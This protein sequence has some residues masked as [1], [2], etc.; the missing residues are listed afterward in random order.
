[1]KSGAKVEN[2]WLSPQCLG[3][4][5]DKAP[6]RRAGFCAYGGGEYLCSVTAEAERQARQLIRKTRRQNPHAQIVVTG[7]A[8]QIDPQSWQA[9]DEVDAVMG[10]H[11]KLGAE[12]WQALAAHNSGDL[13]SYIGDIMQVREVAPH[14]LSGFD[15]K[16]RAFL[17]IQQG[18]DHRCS[19]CIIPYGRGVSRSVSRADTI[20][21]IEMLVA[22]GVQEVV[23]TGV[24]ISSWGYDLGGYDLGADAPPRLG[25]LVKAILQAVPLLPRLRLSSLDPA[26]IDAD[27]RDAFGGEER[28]MPHAHLSIQHGDGLMLKRMKR[29]HSPDDVKDLVEDLRARRRDIVFGGDIIAGF[30]TETDEAHQRS[31]EF[32]ESL[33]ISWLHIFPF[34][35]RNGTP[36]ARMPQVSGG[37]IRARAGEFRQLGAA[38]AQRQLDAMV[39]RTDEVVLETGGIAHTRQFAKVVMAAGEARLTAGARYPVRILRAD[40]QFLHAEALL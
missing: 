4:R 2:F 39:G 8:A 9:M 6:Y 32:I 3:K 13:P 37:V 26:D 29:R 36:A 27:L 34:S 30:P 24:D 31:L 23:L 38:L 7:C 1:M 28:L 25:Q 17:Q 21:Q 20:A 18:C 14:L 22:N 35:P 11:E 19:F 10:N 33:N 15:H 12:N 16:A 40:D 5:G